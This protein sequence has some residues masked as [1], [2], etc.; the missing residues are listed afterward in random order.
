[1]APEVPATIPVGSGFERNQ[2]KPTCI[3]NSMLR[4]CNFG[5]HS[6]SP[7]VS[8]GNNYLTGQ[9]YFNDNPE[10]PLD[11]SLMYSPGHQFLHP[12]LADYDS[13]QIFNT[14]APSDTVVNPA[15]TRETLSN[16]YTLESRPELAISQIIEE[17]RSAMANNLSITEANFYSP[18]GAGRN[19]TSGYQSSTNHLSQSVAP[20]G[21]SDHGFNTSPTSY[22]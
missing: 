11:G 20:R 13:P 3:D 22:A 8:P 9:T 15:Q 21:S 5:V 7:G 19:E 1:M 18:K 14:T 2:Y 6:P 4:T 17:T 16:R 10:T 12:T